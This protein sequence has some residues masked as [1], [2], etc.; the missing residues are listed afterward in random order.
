[1]AFVASGSCGGA[2]PRDAVVANSIVSSAT[3]GRAKQSLTA[4]VLVAVPVATARPRRLRF[5]R[6]GGNSPFAAPHLLCSRDC[7]STAGFS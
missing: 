5:W 7:F 2:G 1:M 4:A 6:I 3:L